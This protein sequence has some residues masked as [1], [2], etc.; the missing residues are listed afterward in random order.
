VKK[1]L[2]G[3]FS[4]LLFLLAA[5]VTVADASDINVIV[6]GKSVSFPDAR[7]YIS[8]ENRTM[9]PVRFISEQLGAQVNWIAGSKSVDIQYGAKKILLPLNKKSASVNGQ[10]LALDA[11]AVIKDNRTMVPLRFISEV[12]GARVLW[13]SASST[14]RISTSAYDASVAKNN[15]KY[16][17]APKTSIEPKKQYVAAVTTNRGAFKIKLLTAAAPVTVNN[18]IFLAKEGFY[19]GTLFHRIMKDFMIQ[20]GD[21][22]GTGTGGPGYSFADELPPSVPYGPGVVAMANSGPN[23]NGSQFFICNG[24]GAGNL[25]K[26]PNYT[27]FGQ[28]IEGMD[29]VYLISDTPVAQNAM[30]EYSQPMEEV[31]I[32]KVTIEEK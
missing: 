5:T 32:E 29:V 14:V 6:N 17:E 21:P 24:A 15:G 11:P 18:F 28:V 3:L 12:L 22:T 1:R 19:N 2:I 27:V 25:N 23:T 30:G 8:Q 13:N 26:N 31:Y 16:R 9:V 10:E 7:A 20:G 4:M